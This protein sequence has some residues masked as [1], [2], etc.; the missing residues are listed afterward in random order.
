M[1]SFKSL[2]ADM[3]HRRNSNRIG[4][5]G[6]RNYNTNHP[7]RQQQVQNDQFLQLPV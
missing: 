1:T 7:N 5:V 3:T 6:C 2:R 4:F